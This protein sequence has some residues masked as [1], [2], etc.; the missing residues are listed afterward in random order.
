[1]KRDILIPTLRKLA[2]QAANLQTEAKRLG[3]FT[4]D[5]ELLTCPKCG[6]M[7]DVRIDGRLFTCCLD[8]PNSDTGLRFVEYDGSEGLFRCPAC[9]TEIISRRE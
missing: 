1:M 4:D 7:E 8:D 3:L 2:K 6:L 9:G 5:R